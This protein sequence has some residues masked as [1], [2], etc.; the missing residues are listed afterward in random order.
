MCDLW[1]GVL[2]LRWSIE[3]GSIFRTTR[4]FLGRFALNAIMF[5]Q[6]RQLTI[7]QSQPY[8]HIY[9]DDLAVNARLDTSKELGW[10]R[11]EPEPLAD[12]ERVVT[13]R[14]FNSLQVFSN[15]VIKSSK[16]HSI[17]GEIFFYTRVPDDIRMLFPRILDYQYLP[18]T[19]TYTMTL[20]KLEGM[21]Y[22]HCKWPEC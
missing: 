22:S 13:P 17:L 21:T 10:W 5:S 19:G 8:A 11:S 20:E 12:K 2:N 16:T 7:L 14:S 9:V 15:K 6:A 3:S 4:F 18:E 1:E